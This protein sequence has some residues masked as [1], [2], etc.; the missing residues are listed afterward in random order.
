MEFWRVVNGLKAANQLID[1]RHARAM[2]SDP[3]TLAKYSLEQ[4]QSEHG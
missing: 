3:V 2:T 4:A 1:K